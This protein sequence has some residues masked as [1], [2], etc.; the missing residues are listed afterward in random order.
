MS[1]LVHQTFE[2]ELIPAWMPSDGGGVVKHRSP[3]VTLATVFVAF[4]IMFTVNMLS[5]QPGK[6]SAGT[7]DAP[8]ASASGSAG[9]E[10]PQADRDRRRSPFPSANVSDTQ[11]GSAAIAEAVLGNQ[12]AAYFCDGRYVES[13]FG[14]TDGGADIP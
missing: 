11:D 9:S 12:A 4:A 2:G 1:E 5:G 14:G 3:L 13:W 6:S 8:A 10:S 7:A